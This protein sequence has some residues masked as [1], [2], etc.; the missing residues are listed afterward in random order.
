MSIGRCAL[1]H[2]TLQG[3]LVHQANIY[4]HPICDSITVSFS[5]YIPEPLLNI[6]IPHIEVRYFTMSS[7]T[8]TPGGK[9]DQRPAAVP[10]VSSFDQRTTPG[11]KSFAVTDASAAHHIKSE[12]TWYQL[13]HAEI[14]GMN[15]RG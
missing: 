5:T 8:T 1:A 6:Y 7:T 11:R 13:V 4:P 10:L 2:S 3:K 14:I 9:H 15:E 12:L